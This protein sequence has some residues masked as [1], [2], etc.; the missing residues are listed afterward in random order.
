MAA[1]STDFIPADGA[2]KSA[3]AVVSVTSET[4]ARRT[5]GFRAPEAAARSGAVAASSCEPAV[6]TPNA[7]PAESTTA[8]S[9]T[10]SRRAPAAPMPVMAVQPRPEATT[11]ATA[12]PPPVSA[13]FAT[14]ANGTEIKG[15]PQTAK[16]CASSEAS[17]RLIAAAVLRAVAIAAPASTPTQAGSQGFAAQAGKAVLPYA[18]CSAAVLV[19][20]ERSEQAM[21]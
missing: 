18:V 3:K 21:A 20:V 15:T 11:K 16:I 8:Q 19:T 14:T 2:V 12:S 4:A 17:G 13:A 6:E 9:T 10:T 1:T 7:R 5:A